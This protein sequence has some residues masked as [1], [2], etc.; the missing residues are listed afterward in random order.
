MPKSIAQFVA[1]VLTLLPV[2]AAAAPDIEVKGLFA[3]RAV[4]EINGEPRVVR[5]G[6]RTDEGVLLV[7]ST[8][9]EAVIE[10]NGVRQT[11]QLSGQIASTFTEAR[12]AEVRISQSPDSHFRVSGTINGFPVTMMVDTGATAVAMNANDAERLGIDYLAG[13]K[14]QASTASGLVESYMVDLNSIKVGAI[15]VYN[16]KA[17]VLQGDYPTQIL[18]GNTFLRHVEMEQ[19]AGSLILRRKF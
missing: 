14:G 19:K 15:D 18:L 4:L 13:Q 2:L 8:S 1:A 3:G 17:V 6:E 5:A 7:S 12:A 10:V 16:I 9:R 11:L